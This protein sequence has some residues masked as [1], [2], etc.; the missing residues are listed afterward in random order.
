MVMVGRSVHL[1]TLFS[2]A[3]LN[4]Q[5]TSTLCTNFGC[6]WQLISQ[7]HNKM[8]V[9]TINS[10]ALGSTAEYVASPTVDQGVMSLIPARSHTFAEIDREIIFTFIF[11][12][13]LI[14][15]GLCQLQAKVCA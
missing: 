2:W 5:L 12:H 13:L 7:I 15:E 6:N 8:L 14:Q 3:G 11:L 9:L 10:R 4:K 1:T